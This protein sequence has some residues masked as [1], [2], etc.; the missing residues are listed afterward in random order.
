MEGSE[1]P[2][3]STGHFR[4]N[5]VQAENIIIRIGN[6]IILVPRPKIKPAQ[7][8]RNPNKFFVGREIALEK[9]KTELSKETRLA[10]TAIKG[11]GG[12]GKTE[13]A[14]QYAIAATNSNQYPGGI[15]WID[16][17]GKDVADEILDFAKI[18]LDF[19]PPDKQS[20]GQE[21]DLPKKV[22]ACWNLWSQAFP[23]EKLVIFDDV[24]AY[25][26]VKDFLPPYDPK[27]KV[28]ITTRLR[29]EPLNIA[30]LVLEVLEEEYALDLLEAYIG[31]ERLIN[32]L[33]NAKK[34]CEWVG[35][36]P[37]GL[38]L[39]GRYLREFKED[40]L[41]E[42]LEQLKKKGLDQA[43]M[44][45]TAI[46]IGN[47][48]TTADL[49]EGERRLYESVYA[50]FNLNWS[51]LRQSGKQLGAILSLFDAPAYT[52]SLV[53][54][55]VKPLD[56]QRGIAK[57]SLK[58][59]HLIHEEEDN[60]IHP[61][62]QD[63]FI[64]KLKEEQ[65]FLSIWSVLFDNF[66][67]QQYIYDTGYLDNGIERIE[68]IRS[69]L[70]EEDVEGQIIL[71]KMIGHSYYADRREEGT[72]NAVQNFLM[73]RKYVK[74]RNSI[75]FEGKHDA[76]LWY[77][78]FCLDHAHNLV[79]PKRS[80]EIEG[81]IFT[82]KDLEAAIDEL[83]PD[84]LK[85]LSTPPSAVVA[86]YILRA[87]HY[88]GHRGNQYGFLLFEDIQNLSPEKFEE[89]YTQGIESYAKAA[90]FRLVNFRLSQPDEYENHLKALLIN[91]PYVP[92]WLSEWDSSSFQ[93]HD[94][95]LERFTSSAQAIGDTAHQYRGIADIRLWGYLY[96]A[97][98][99]KNDPGFI[100]EAEKLVK[101]TKDLWKAAQQM[102][103]KD[104]KEKI[105]KYYLWMAN[106]E[107]KFELAR[108][109]SRRE[110]LIS[111]EE[112]ENRLIKDLDKLED[113]YRLSYAWARQVAMDQLR[114][115]YDF[116]KTLYT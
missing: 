111:L 17:R 16:V 29:L 14:L 23:E 112:A 73:A 71:S 27:L 9:L 33:D 10:I 52:W 11:M 1:I 8:K 96:Q 80:I 46:P 28:I 70:P 51:Q 66:V 108:S 91:A 75:N 87:A 60:P 76:W 37:L 79:V 32:E 18:Y 110:T 12:I 100:Q 13:L 102:L 44:H 58:D 81:K 114:K 34:L 49:I 25:D 67:F 92:Q 38:N 26:Q 98:Q 109:H 50:V 35:N 69:V 89:L 31:R 85:Q 103:N 19:I 43:A 56:E 93:K 57:I 24:A 68:R 105:I 21:I 22:A 20:S 97:K 101:V 2:S 5:N 84:E 65:E 42:L 4:F 83:L 47:G 113:K 82:S 95:T 90:V 30:S 63:F 86:P 7:L 61:L 116:L 88:W 48:K 94:I 64:K 45:E 77:Q 74:S 59:L 106:L 107:T 41:L 36:L 62:I 104:I 55:A 115:F 54:K 53:E 40:T 6:E 3:I 72:R 78:L 39:V 15:C 99:G